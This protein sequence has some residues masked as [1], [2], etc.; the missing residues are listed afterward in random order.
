VKLFAA[1]L[2]DVIGQAGGAFSVFNL[3][4]T[5]I[6]A[7]IVPSWILE[8]KGVKIVFVSRL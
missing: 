5:Q 3:A 1:C 2:A 4:E 8:S 6:Y 7:V